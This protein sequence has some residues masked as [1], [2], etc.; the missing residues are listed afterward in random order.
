MVRN[1]AGVAGVADD[2]L[3][4]DNERAGHLEDVAHS[5]LNVVTPPGS[6]NAARYG[7]RT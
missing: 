7:G 1:V 4:I 5:F 6:S 3:T 2:T